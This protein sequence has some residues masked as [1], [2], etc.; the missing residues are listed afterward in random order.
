MVFHNVTPARFVELMTELKKKYYGV[1][2]QYQGNADMTKE[3]DKLYNRY[4]LNRPILH[5]Q[6]TAIK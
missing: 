1:I 4:Y 6:V 5:R 3:A 2:A